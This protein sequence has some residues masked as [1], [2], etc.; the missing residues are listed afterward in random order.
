[1]KHK[2]LVLL[3]AATLVGCSKDDVAETV[4]VKFT[5]SPKEDTQSRAS[6]NP[7][8]SEEIIWNAGDK[9]AVFTQTG[10]TTPYEF[11]LTE[12]AGT[13]D[14]AFEGDIASD[15]NEVIGIY[16]YSDKW[17]YNPS[18]NT[19]TLDFLADQTA[20]Y[21]TYDPR[22][23]IMF[24]KTNKQV[25]DFEFTNTVGYVKVELPIATKSITLQPLVGDDGTEGGVLSSPEVRLNTVTGELTPTESNPSRRDVTLLP[26]KGW[27]QIPAGTYYLAVLPTT[28]TNGFWLSYIDTNDKMHLR[29][30]QK[31][32][33][34]KPNHVTLIGETTNENS[35]VLFD[36]P[37]KALELINSN[38]TQLTGLNFISNQHK[39]A[40]ITQD[41]WY[42]LNDNVLTFF[43]T[44]DRYVINGDIIA[45][46]W[47]AG[48]LK[49]INFGDTSFPDTKQ[50]TFV[51]AVNLESVTFGDNF[52][53]SHINSLEAAFWTCKK[54]KNVDFGK[55]ISNAKFT[56]MNGTFKWCYALESVDLS[57]AD[58]SNVTSMSE[59]FEGCE[60]LKT[61]DM[62]GW[63]LSSVS[64]M[65]SMF[66]G[67]EGLE[68]VNFGSALKSSNLTTMAYMFHDCPNL[69]SLDLSGSNVSGN[70]NLE[71]LVSG[72]SKLKS[73]KFG[74]NFKT[75]N[76]DMKCMFTD[77][78]SLT[79]VDV[80]NLSTNNVELMF[81]MFSG[82]ES[83]TDLDLSSF[84]THDRCSNMQGMFLN[85]HSLVNL[86]L[87]PKFLFDPYTYNLINQMFNR[88]GDPKLTIWNA[89]KGTQ[90]RIK[91][92]FNSNWF[93]FKSK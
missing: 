57:N 70:L 78:S 81:T 84:D 4:H 55:G 77:C 83:L 19:V 74:N 21:G 59:M 65:S 17:N 28:L 56:S 91:S 23:G 30:Y 39:P 41:Y 53:W 58:F 1:M 76:T 44:K 43:T 85:C 26:A 72:C 87:G 60:N 62:S 24:A 51:G 63:N 6:F 90:D 73:V 49:S 32:Y 79:D 37:N 80:N 22:T 34:V 31:E 7:K 45:T 40:G 88:D 92:M 29:S 67:C 47:I 54:L 75:N 9:L 38:I 14:G 3:A 15:Y 5:A 46:F 33:E 20:T 71:H 2:L 82:C 50:L 61:M 89:P 68:S 18:D 11:T 27:S 16:P 25:A 36:D 66:S 10:R 35:A 86:Y 48:K 64:D 69:E 8:D 13:N 42:T 12:G 93:E 52:D